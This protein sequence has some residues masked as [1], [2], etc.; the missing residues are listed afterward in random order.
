M[1]EHVFCMQKVISSISI[2]EMYLADCGI[3]AHGMPVCNILQ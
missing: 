3:Y 2:L 1:L